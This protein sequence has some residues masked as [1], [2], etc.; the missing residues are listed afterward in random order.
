[1]NASLM[2]SRGFNL[3][4]VNKIMRLLGLAS[5]SDSTTPFPLEIEQQ[6][7]FGESTR[8]ASMG[9]SKQARRRR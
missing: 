9:E 5:L 6:V 2:R 8:D 7:S 3:V 1:M 4:E